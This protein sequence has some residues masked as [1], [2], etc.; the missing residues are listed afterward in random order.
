M[1]STVRFK[2]K[3]LVTTV[4]YALFFLYIVIASNLLFFSSYRQGV[5]AVRYGMAD[6]NI[7][8]LHTISNYIKASSHIN[9]SIVVMNIAG[10]VLAFMPLGF[11]LPLLFRR[12]LNFGRALLFFFG[13]TLT[14]ECLQ[15]LFHVGS[16]DVDDLIL[17][18][19]GGA[20]GFLIFK[21]GY[22]M[23]RPFLRGEER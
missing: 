17:N 9:M 11:F 12:Y 4:S 13:T 10:N 19:V 14:V 1:F 18:T 7:V 20:I 6:Y 16:F 15:F 23:V 2:G 5:R 21:I 22:R 8:P 3:K